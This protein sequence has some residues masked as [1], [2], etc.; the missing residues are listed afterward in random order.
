MANLLEQAERER[1]EQEARAWQRLL[2]EQ[3]SRS[4]T[5]TYRAAADARVKQRTLAS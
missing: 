3:F 4:Q 1:A 5:T 2:G